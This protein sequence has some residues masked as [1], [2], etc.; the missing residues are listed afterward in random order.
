MARRRSS[1]GTRR[2][3]VPALTGGV[4]TQPQE[5]R[6]PNQVNEAINVTVDMVRG[7]EKRDGTK[8]LGTAALPSTSAP[9]IGSHWFRRDD[10]ELYLMI[11]QDKTIT[12]AT[13]SLRIFN[14]LDSTAGVVTECSV[15]Y[16]GGNST[17]AETYFTTTGGTCGFINISDTA[18]IYNDAVVVSL[19]STDLNST[20]PDPDAT[21]ITV[22]DWSALGTPA[23]S[24]LYRYCTSDFPGHPS[25]WWKSISISTL[26]Y[27]ERARTPEA[28]SAF[29]TTTM[30]LQLRCTAKNTFEISVPTWVDRLAGDSDTNP[31]PSFVGQKINSM[32]YFGGRLWVG[33]GQQLVSSQTE[34]LL[35]FWIDSYETLKDTDPIDLTVG[36]DSPMSI[37]HTVPY[38]KSLVVFTDSERQ[39]EVRAGTSGT[40]SPTNVQLFDTTAY[41]RST[42]RPTRINNL[43]YF[44]TNGGGATRLYEYEVS[45]EGV[46]STAVDVTSHAYGYIPEGVMEITAS[47]TT[48]QIFMHTAG[49]TKLYVYQQA[50]AGNEKIQNAVISWDF[51]EQ[52][53]KM[54]IVGSTLY[55]L[56]NRAGTWRVESV[57][58]ARSRDDQNQDSFSYPISLDG[59][60]HLTG[61][62]ANGTTTWTSAT[63]GDT[64]SIGVLGNDWKDRTVTNRAGDSV[65]VDQSGVFIGV[66][67]VG[68][69][70]TASGDWSDYPVWF[71]RNVDMT[72]QLSQQYVRDENMT[73]V[74]GTLQLKTMS[75]KHKETGYFEV[76]VTPPGRS[77]HTSTYTGKQ[78]GSFTW[79]ANAFPDR[80]IH[81]TKVMSSA[82]GVDIKFVSDSP[83]PCNLT[84]V[85]MIGGF[86]PSKPSSTDF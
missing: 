34:D 73:A 42:T 75:T 49:S 65:V 18:F 84:S 76:Q 72:C 44:P 5:Q 56:F 33:A 50:Y 81:R 86:V 78:I 85:E 4:S 27:W 77:P 63:S 38:S 58:T 68:N 37:E 82:N 26:P 19:D 7:L 2:I 25:G 64:I 57:Y 67:Q 62:Y 13:N 80:G 43:L 79:E 31:G 24:G 28:N 59:K 8:L 30:P 14:V 70:L 1:V 53:Q 12:G 45:E 54:T 60:Q 29:D 10:D 66:T 9:I 6:F 48:D 32:S 52:I 17:A 15:S 16:P 20:Y 71:G 36:S 55:L 46:P 69:T 22:A 40:L 74:D 39:F 51:G 11:I 47:S 61:T 41:P 3:S 23:S 83:A 21:G 35:N